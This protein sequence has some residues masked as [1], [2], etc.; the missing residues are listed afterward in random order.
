[1]LENL[2]NS[3]KEAPIVKKGDYDYFVH[4]ITDGIPKI[5]AELLKEVAIEIEKIAN[6]DCDKIVTAEAMGIPIGTALSL[7]TGLPLVIIR[8]RKYGLEGEVKVLQTTG[9]SKTQMY[10]NGI[11]KGERVV[12]IDDVLSTGG[13][14]IAIVNALRKIGAKITDIIIVIEKCKKE[15]IEKIIGKN[16]KTLVKV[17]IVDGKVVVLDNQK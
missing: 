15:K 12:I 7:K 13:T 1:M 4:P 10:I 16:I 6:L 8:K 2:K 11:K 14:L 3:L 17:E 9:Y 5:E